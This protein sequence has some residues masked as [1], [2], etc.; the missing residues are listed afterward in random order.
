METEDAQTM[1]E[2]PTAVCKIIER[3]RQ[4]RAAERLS[5]LPSRSE[6]TIHPPAASGRL[7]STHH[8]WNGSSTGTPALAKSRTCRV[9]TVRPWARAVA[10]TR[11][12]LTGIV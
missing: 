11:L 2:D 1:E 5:G 8:P 6:V 10:A 9:T 7:S 3:P 12:S 4:I